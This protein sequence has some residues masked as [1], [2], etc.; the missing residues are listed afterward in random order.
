MNTL[1]LKLILAPALIGAA[2][3]AGRRW[4]PAISGSLV[5]LPLTSAPV[6][7]IL[8]LSQ[9]IPF[10]AATTLGILAGAISPALFALAYAWV[11]RQR[12]WPAALLAG[13][14]IYIPVTAAL[15]A[16]LVA[17]PP[18]PIPLFLLVVVV[19][20]VALR[21]MP[22]A[23]A[24]A[25]DTASTKSAAAPAW[26]L[27]ARMGVATVFVFL[28]TSAASTLGPELTGLLSP[29]PLY[30]SILAIFAHQQQG[31]GAAITVLRGLLL[32]MFSFTSFFLT[33]SLLLQPAGIALTF[34][35]AA[36]VALA[37][38]AGALWLLRRPRRSAR[39]A[40]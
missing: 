28:L 26:D 4:G 23:S 8:A 3:L 1:A 12:A 19:L 14:A 13:L 27:P 38:Q 22:T 7:F 18:S 21:L 35:A 29:F 36:I 11:A 17:W 30:A 37:L 40:D 31:S 33:L 15:R 16:A 32:G 39:Q 10:A 9:G 24:P 34:A 6:V 2:S 5:G 25:S 20:A